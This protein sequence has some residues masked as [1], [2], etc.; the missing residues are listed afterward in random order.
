MK[1]YKEKLLDPRWQKKRLEIFE[2]DKWTCRR[3][4]DRESTLHV[5]HLRYHKGKEPWEYEDRI[6]L[7]LCDDCHEGETESRWEE[8]QTLLDAVAVSGY[9]SE[10]INELYVYLV[11]IEKRKLLDGLRKIEKGVK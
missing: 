1:T 3:C 6:L 7:T 11:N 8:Q 4:G 10:D 2:R 5:H 9:F